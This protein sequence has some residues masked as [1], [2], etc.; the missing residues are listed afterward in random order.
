MKRSGIS[1]YL[2]HVDHGEGKRFA[3]LG[4]GNWN[5][6]A[7]VSS[8]FGAV[9][10]WQVGRN[11]LNYPYSTLNFSRIIESNT[12]I[13]RQEKMLKGLRREII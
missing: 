11:S 8:D 4:A 12:E 3:R 5:R 7:M 6:T 10:G 13:G 9:S 1:L 2:G